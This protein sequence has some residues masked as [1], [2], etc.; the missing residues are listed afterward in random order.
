MK[1]LIALVLAV[2]MLVGLLAACDEKETTAPT[3]G[4]TKPTT[5]PTEPGQTE[6]TKLDYCIG[7]NDGYY[8]FRDYTAVSP[9][10]W[11]ELTY[12]D[13][14]DSTLI[15][16]LNSSFFTYDFVFDPITGEPIDGEYTVKYAAVIDL[17][18]VTA[19]YKEAWGL[20]GDTGFAYKFTLRDDL[21]WDNGDPIVAEDFIYSM[22]EQLNPLF[23]NYRADSFYAGSVNIVGAQSYAKQGLSLDTVDNGSAKIYAMEDLVKGENGVYTQPDGNPVYFALT[24]GLSWCSGNSVA[25][26]ANA[27]Y[28]DAEAFAALKALADAETG[29]VAVTDES[30]ALWLQ[31]I[32][33]DSWGHEDASY[34]FNYLVYPYT[35]PEFSWDNVGLLATGKYEMVVLLTNPLELIDEEGNLTYHCGYDF[36]GLPL[37]H[38]ET[39]EACKVAPQEGSEL[40]TT[41]YNTSLETTRSWGQYV[42][43]SFQT[44]KE[45]VVERNT[46]WYGYYLPEHEGLY[47]TDRIVVETIKEW[48]T[49][50]LKFL[51]GQIDGIG[52]DPTIADEYKGS[53]RAIFTPDDYIQSAQ[54]QSNKEALEN[55]ETAG[56]NKT[57]L[58]YTDFRMAMSLAVNRADYANKCTTSSLAGFGIFNSMHYYDVANGGVYRNTDEAKEVLCKVYG[59]DVSKFASLDEAVNSITG[60]NLDKAREL[61]TAAYNQALAD[62]EIS[63]TDKVVLTYGS[64]TDNESTRRHYDYLS[65]AWIE[66]CVGTPL[67]GRI[68]IEFDA[69]FGTKWAT[70]FRAGAYD[71]CMGG[72]S[73][74]AWDPGYFLLAYLDPGYKYAAGWDTDAHMMTFT[75]KGVGEN[76]ADITETMS[77]MDWYACLNGLSG[78]KYDWSEAAL[79]QEQRLQLIAA[80]EGE[81]LGTYYTVPMFYSFGASL[82]SYKLDYIT[83]SYNTFMGYGGL[84]YATYKYTDEEWANAVFEQGGE[85]DYKR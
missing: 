68:E 19:E 73:G 63:A 47:Q 48:G 56:V 31:L 59:I 81:V 70:D 11:N 82:L 32:D 24:E 71:I 3:E 74:A 75:M 33:T 55:R 8:T 28:L 37:V 58:T 77:L 67:E 7:T 76:G 65:K 5:K 46:K 83:R 80:L 57:I 60:Y 50:W 16:Y 42:L 54:L 22:Q 85:L 44:D 15:S 26:Y 27:G 40:W 18:D 79:K 21:V 43:T 25:A 12:Q 64:S 14:N 2:L 69:S 30:I 52:I 10:N 13:A 17:Q 78:C 9:S 53:S 20:A 84:K 29:R 66:M 51:A 61:V 36:S 23:Q 41:T 62:G 6:P 34:L 38:K 4:T 39:Y 35:Y 49:A 1:K 45:F 72:W